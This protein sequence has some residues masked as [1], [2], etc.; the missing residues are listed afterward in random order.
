MA[1]PSWLDAGVDDV[2]EL[3]VGGERFITTRTTLIKGSSYFAEALADSDGRE[4]GIFLDQDSDAFRVILS[5]L[6]SNSACL[7]DDE[8]LASRVVRLALFLGVDG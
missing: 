7:P 5:F 6:R 4:G 1:L 3:N 8:A 2:L